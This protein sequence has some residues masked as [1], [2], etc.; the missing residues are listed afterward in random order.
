MGGIMSI[1][2][3]PSTTFA[4]AVVVTTASFSL[5]SNVNADNTKK[6]K[7]PKH[8]FKKM[9]SP[10]KKPWVKTRTDGKKTCPKGGKLQAGKCV[11][12]VKPDEACPEG[13]IRP[14]GPE[15]KECTYFPTVELDTPS[16][17]G[18]PTTGGSATTPAG[19][20]QV[21]K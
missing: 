4:T 8:K 16:Q 1:V 12:K 14:G 10:I 2:S 15:G 3:V 19:Q 20:T 9:K 18:E 21:P 6:Q 11:I 17:D 5:M 13:T 7:V